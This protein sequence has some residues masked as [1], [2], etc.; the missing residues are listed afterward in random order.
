MNC[1]VCNAGVDSEVIRPSAPG[2]WEYRY[3]A[4]IIWT[5]EPGTKARHRCRLTPRKYE[6]ELLRE[7]IRSEPR[8]ESAP[9]VERSNPRKRYEGEL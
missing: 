1:S 4:L 7:P 9:P 5:Y 6:E 8:T 2:D 3:A